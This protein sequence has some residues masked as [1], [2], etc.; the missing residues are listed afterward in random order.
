MAGGRPP[1][2]PRGAT[3]DPSVRRAGLLAAAEDAIR[4]LG[5]DVSMEQ[6]A[7]RA[8]VS[9][10]TLY[11]NFDG[12]AG[13]T[14]ALI[15]RYGVRIMG[16][17]AD[18]IRGP[19]DPRGIVANGLRIFV[20]FIATDPEIY[21]FI[22]RHAEG[23]ELL[24]DIAEQLAGLIGQAGGRDPQAAAVAILGATFTASEW[25]SRTGALD[26]ERFVDLLTE[27]VWGGLVAT[28]LADAERPVDLT[29]LAEVLSPPRP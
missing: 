8:D 26:E 29:E 17:F 21:R 9:K 4:E 28:G 18:S 25:W 6:I 15:E 23:N 22:V 27:F 14:D 10:A 2:R 3:Q 20:H 12:K 5:P 13:L 11:D 16:A 19:A 7:E 1:G 24:D